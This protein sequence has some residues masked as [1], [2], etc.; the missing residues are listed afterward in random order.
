MPKTGNTDTRVGDDHRYK[1]ESVRLPDT[2]VDIPSLPLQD[3]V[4]AIRTELV[5]L[6]QRENRD[7]QI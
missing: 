7:D 3:E 5:L 6:Q 2:R 1:Q 4:Q